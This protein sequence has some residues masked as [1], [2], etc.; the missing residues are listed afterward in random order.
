MRIATHCDSVLGLKRNHDPRT[1]LSVDLSR[2]V[3]IR[4]R[5][6][7][8]RADT[9]YDSRRRSERE[10]NLPSALVTDFSC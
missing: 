9:A 4:N 10:D 2:A 3:S 7:P 6:V 8:R 1:S 5:Y